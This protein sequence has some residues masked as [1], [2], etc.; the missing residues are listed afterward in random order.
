MKQKPYVK[1]YKNGVLKNP[2]TK[3]NP[4]LFAPKLN[5]RSSFRMWIRQRNKFFIGRVINY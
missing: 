1:N 5:Y 4:Y 2:I 3:E